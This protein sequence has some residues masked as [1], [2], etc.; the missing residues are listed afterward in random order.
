MFLFVA[1]FTAINFIPHL[2]V[3][4]IFA[5]GLALITTV[6]RN[7]FGENNLYAAGFIMILLVL[8]ME[9]IIYVNHRAKANLFMRI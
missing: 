7:K 9:S 4:E 8:G 5:I 3:R 1:N 6:T 2:V